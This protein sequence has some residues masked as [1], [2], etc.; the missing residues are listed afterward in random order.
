[1][2]LQE[3]IPEGHIPDVCNSGFSYAES[4]HEVQTATAR[5]TVVEK[6]K[7]VDDLHLGQVDG[8]KSVKVRC[9][10]KVFHGDQTSVRL[11]AWVILSSL[12]VYREPSS[13]PKVFRS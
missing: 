2:D 1:L 8:I 10:D 6:K 5:L 13:P 9:T 12:Q 4:R 7:K 11:T 3:A